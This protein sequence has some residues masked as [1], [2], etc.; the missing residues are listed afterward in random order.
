MDCSLP[1][2]SVYGVLQARI[3]EWVAISFSRGIFPA[4]GLNPRFLHWQKNSVPWATREAQAIIALTVFLLA[5]ELLEWR[6]S[7]HL[8]SASCAPEKLKVL[9][10]QSCPTLCHSVDCS[11]PGSSVHVIF[12]ARIL[13]WAAILFSRGSSHPRDWTWVSCFAG[14]F[15]MIQD[16]KPTISWLLRC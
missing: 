14:R 2:S 12:Q 4:Q 11:P 16:P 15:F 8:I 9:A 1:G 5:R 10:A 3:L 13:E 6:Y 7:C